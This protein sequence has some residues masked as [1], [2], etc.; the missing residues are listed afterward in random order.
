MLW[1]WEPD[2]YQCSDFGETMVVRHSSEE[3]VTSLLTNCRNLEV[4][5][6]NFTWDHVFSCWLVMCRTDN[7]SY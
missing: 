1:I 5:Y 7:R 4:L 2:E 3:N 6:V